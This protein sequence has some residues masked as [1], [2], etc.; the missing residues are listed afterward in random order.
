MGISPLSS[1]SSTPSIKQPTTMVRAITLAF[2]VAVCVAVA[3]ALPSG[4]A[5]GAGGAPAPAYPQAQYH[6]SPATS[7]PFTDFYWRECKVE[8]GGFLA[9]CDKCCFGGYTRNHC[10]KANCYLPCQPNSGCWID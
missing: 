9:V 4:G 5:G 10:T 3:S 7:V 6:S 1:G 2:V 8:H